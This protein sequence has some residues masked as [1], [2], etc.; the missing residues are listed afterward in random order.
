MGGISKW[1]VTPE[2]KALVL[3]VLERGEYVA[4]G[5]QNIAFEREFA[6]YIGS[7]YAAVVSSGG[8]GLHIAMS[9]LGIGP[10]DEVIVPANTYTAVAGCPVWVGAKP[11]LV[12]MEPDTYNIDPGKIE[13]N[14]TPRTKAIIPVHMY[15]QPADMDPIMELAE[16]HGLFVV[17]DA[18][19]G[20]GS[21]Y[22][23]RKSGSIG[24]VNVFAFM[25][26]NM[27]CYGT[28][29]MITTDNRE[30]LRK[31]RLYRKFGH[32]V[33]LSGARAET[34]DCEVPGYNYEL[35]GWNSALGRISLR[36]LDRWN[37]RRRENARM[38]RDLLEELPNVVLPVERNWACHVYLWYVIQAEKRNKLKEFLARK[39]IE[40]SIIYSIP[41][42]LQT[43]FRQRFSFRRDM[44][45]VTEAA[46]RKI[47]SLPIGFHLKEEQIR[48]VARCI[49]KFYQ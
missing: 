17:E 46:T 8:G 11:V 23:E 36:S 38:Y 21:K 20:A 40:T 18:A 14:V 12:D 44:Y 22:K 39:G 26:K 25:G 32:S 24:D 48:Y 35:A 29:G 45:P 1:P 16:R 19:Q 28:G 5:E 33:T 42:H 13:E 37:K 3:E 4:S 31:I 10:G 2:M 49:K 30:Y 47:L 6:K 41:I 27:H 34:G 15:G 7:K 9:V 43:A